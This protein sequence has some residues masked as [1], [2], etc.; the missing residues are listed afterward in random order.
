MVRRDFVA[1]KVLDLTS[2]LRHNVGFVGLRVYSMLLDKNAREALY[3]HIWLISIP[4]KELFQALP[5][6]QV[7]LDLH[8]DEGAELV[9]WLIEQRLVDQA[10]VGLL[11]RV[12][13][14][15]VH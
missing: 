13:L 3:S 9:L 14:R 5:T 10:V 8:W 1:S 2:H 7:E 4:K 15:E 11:E 12:E 6:L